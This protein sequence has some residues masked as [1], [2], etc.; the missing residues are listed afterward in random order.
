MTIMPRKAE[1]STKEPAAIRA[2]KRSLRAASKSAL[3]D[4]LTMALR[5][6]YRLYNLPPEPT[7]QDDGDMRRRKFCASS[8]AAPRRKHSSILA[9]TE[10]E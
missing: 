6:L 10:D 9:P 2:L 3:R 7:L 5:G 1:P 4:R 8:H